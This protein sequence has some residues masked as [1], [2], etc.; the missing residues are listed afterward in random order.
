M[1]YLN[2]LLKLK[3]F[4]ELNFSQ[5]PK[6]LLQQLQG[7]D[8]ID[9]KIVSARKKK[10]IVKKQF[11][12]EYK[13]IKK[14][15]N[16]D[17][18]LELIKAKV[19]SKTKKISPQ[20]GLYINGNCKI[21]NIEL[22]L[23]ENSALFLK[24]IPQI[25]S[26]ILIVCV[27]NFENLVYFRAQIK[28]FQ[29]KKIVFVYRNSMMLKFIEKLENSKNEIIYFGDFDLAGIDIFQSQ[30]LI[31]NKKAKLFIPENIESIIK[32]FGSKELYSKQYSKYK[33]L[34]SQNQKI[35]NLIN[36]INKNQKV[37]EQEYFI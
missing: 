7:E 9:I 18:R 23:F 3:E 34:K 30:V 15:K 11:Y 27:E 28:Y 21:E 2:T 29:E 17:T 12:K 24:E 31:R 35:Q 20:D 36:I 26:D 1:R 5:V 6:T 8:L 13:D 4:G 37:L 22:P 32:E 25:S 33:N 19:H 16:I 14:L 10:I